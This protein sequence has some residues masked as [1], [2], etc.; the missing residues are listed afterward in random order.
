[1]RI[2]NTRFTFALCSFS[3]Y[4]R[5]ARHHVCSCGLPL[6][7][8]WTALD[9]DRSIFYNAPALASCLTACSARFD[10]RGIRHEGHQRAPF[11]RNQAAGS[12]EEVAR[13]YTV[14]YR[15]KSNAI[16]PSLHDIWA[17]TCK[18]AQAHTA[19]VAATTVASCCGH[20][21]KGLCSLRPPERVA[22]SV[23]GPKLALRVSL[24]VAVFRILVSC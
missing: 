12:V 3:H 16:G 21:I 5:I 7:K 17:A 15:R 10:V 2:V 23:D 14:Q 8:T 22:M 24:C 13:G 1:M 20:D 18:L 4:H 11:K 9:L 19:I 6:W